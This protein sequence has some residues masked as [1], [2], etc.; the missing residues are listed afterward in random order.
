MPEAILTILKF[1]FLALLYLFLARVIRVVY[2]ELGGRPGRRA[3]G[4]GGALPR[5]RAGRRARPPSR[6]RVV[7]PAE[8]RGHTYPIGEEVSIGRAAG[9]AISIDDDNYVSQLHSRVFVQNGE[10]Y[11]EDLGSTNGTYL[12]RTRLTHPMPLRVGD[13]I[14]VG[15]TLL[16]AVK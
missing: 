4:A 2:L 3:R 13:R 12:N 1:C 11:V 9:C 16:E 15:K 14:Q 8:S 5:A 7:E 6:L 10:M